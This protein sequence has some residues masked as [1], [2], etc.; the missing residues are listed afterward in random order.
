[1]G[2]VEITI[3]KANLSSVELVDRLSKLELGIAAEISLGAY[4][5]DLLQ[6]QKKKE[7]FVISYSNNY[8][9]CYKEHCLKRPKL[10]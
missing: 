1:M 2:G 9:M 4:A 10:N 5:H 6:R 3:F 7:V 8:G